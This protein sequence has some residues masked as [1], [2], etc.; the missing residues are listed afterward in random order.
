MNKAAAALLLLGLLPCATAAAP[1][2]HHRAAAPA[3]AARG[4]GGASEARLLADA[5]ARDSS[6]WIMN[7]YDPGSLT[8]VEIIA[9]T[10]GGSTVRGNYS[11]N[12]GDSGWV[13]AEIAG[14]RVTCLHYWDTDSC[15]PVRGGSPAPRAANP[16]EPPA[17]AS[18]KTFTAFPKAEQQLVAR[19]WVAYTFLKAPNFESWEPGFT[20]QQRQSRFERYQIR[21]VEI[22]TSLKS[23]RE[24]LALV[25][26]HTA[27]VNALLEREDMDGLRALIHGL[28]RG[29]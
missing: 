6:Y 3:A 16:S 17:A 27:R 13:E 5:I 4:G 28:S 8:D 25:D 1:A 21:Y 18:D 14:G 7:R 23:G 20:Q 11:Y 19:C 15:D 29:C 9:R 10:G 22:S 12:G 2:R 24:F 26:G